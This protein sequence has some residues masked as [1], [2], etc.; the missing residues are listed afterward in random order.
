MK[1]VVLLLTVLCPLLPSQ[2]QL[3]LLP[4]DGDVSAAAGDQAS[5]AI[6]RGGDTTLVVWS[7]N[8]ANPYGVFAWSVYETSRDI[9]GVRLDV[10]G[11]TIDPV[12]FAVVDAPANQTFPKIA[13]NGQVWLVVYQSVDQG[14]TGYY[15]DSLEAVR[16]SAGGEVLD[17]KPIKLFGLIPSGSSYWAVASDG[18]NW[19]VVNQN[20]PTSA[21]IVAVRVSP[22]GVVLDPPTHVLVSGT[23]YQRSNLHLA[24]AGGV[25]ALTYDDNYVNGTNTTK[26]VRFDSNLN[27][28]GA[29]PQPL[30]DVPLAGLASNGN[31]FYLVWDRQEPDFSVHVA[32]SRLGLDGAKLEGNGVNIS[33]TKQPGYGSSTAVAWDGANWRVTWSDSPVLWTARVNASGQVLDPGSVIVAGPRTGPTAGDG[34][35]GLRVVWTELADNN[36]DILTA[37][38]SPGNVAGPSQ[39]LSIG[40]PLQLRS[41]VAAGGD[42][43]MLVFRSSSSSA[44]RILAQPLDAAGSPV[45]SE[46]I[47]LDVG[48]YLNGPGSPN[49]A[50]NGTLYLVTWGTPSGIVAQRLSETGTKIDASPFV[51]MSG[52][53]GPAD[54]AGLGDDFLITGRQLGINVQFIFPVAARVSG[55]GNILDPIPTVLGHSFL[56]TAPAVVALGNRWLVGWHRNATHDDAFAV[57]MGAFV[58]AA[59][60]P[61]P[62]FLIH[63]GFST[64][65]GNGIFE[66]G[67]GSSGE[68]AIFVQSQ[69]LSSGVE[70][71]LLA[72]IIQADGT[73]GPQIS[74]TPWS[75]NQY[76][77]RVAWDGTNFVVAF[78]DQRNRLAVNSLEQLDARSDL[79]AMRVTPSG[80][81][82]DPRGFVFSTNPTSETDPSVTASDGVTLIAGSLVISEEAFAGYRVGYD[83]FPSD[84]PVAVIQPSTLSGDVPLAVNFDSNGSTGISYYWKFGDGGISDAPNPL[85]V[86]YAPG[87]YLVT[88]TVADALGSQTVQAQMI[89][90]TSPNQVPV[91]V[92]TADRYAGNAPLNVVFSARGSYDPDGVIGNVEWLFSDG[93]H[94]YG[95]TAYRTFTTTELKTVTLKCYDARGGIG[96]TEITINVGGTNLP[97]VAQASAAPTNGSA[98]LVVQ[99]SSNGSYDLD[100]N[101]V[102]YSWDFGDVFGAR[103]SQPDP[104]HVYKYAGTYTARLTVTDD[105]NVSSSSTVSIT[106]VPLQIP[107]VLCSDIS[108]SAKSRGGI[109]R[110]TGVLKVVDQDLKGVSRATIT[111]RWTMPDGRT[112]MRTVVSDRRGN[113]RL[114]NFGGH[115]TYT[116]TVVNITSAGH[117]FDP[118]VSVLSASVSG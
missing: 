57:S 92:A 2:A 48:S 11:N 21:D 95:A 37:S 12:P 82:V 6:S 49:V 88:L 26:L 7:D 80:G 43:Y 86:F 81:I 89:N 54:V 23:Y 75:G 93:G 96:I 32:G 106:V 9:Y 71:D 50:W 115:G 18:N 77:P 13:W 97:P 116:L 41:D 60:T 61:T 117:F 1:V 34:V 53:L 76:R 17:A 79:F 44:V 42:G 87:D 8:R 103:S 36:Q 114:T 118:S 85:H 45:S 38:V 66:V 99:F 58:D 25:F 31:S 73:V 4:G 27:L 104:V 30:L 109:V 67:L 72:H 110:V 63:P 19:T 68:A 101:I 102:S 28:L 35:G 40:A 22:S 56:R 64:A 14:G 51:V 29:D 3:S 78:Q 20:T 94:A 83:S 100:G 46:P 55:R 105:N 5:P 107:L 90:A 98:P 39:V 65:G 91:A 15:Q 59:G 69:E 84:G 108:L 52:C 113:A 10:N 62:E 74:L 16:V 111:A 112:Q 47:Q 70:N 24:Y 33:G